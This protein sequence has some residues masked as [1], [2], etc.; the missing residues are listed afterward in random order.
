MQDC[1]VI[2]YII[3]RWFKSNSVRVAQIAQLVEH[4]SAKGK[5]R[6]HDSTFLPAS[7]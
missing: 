1:V 6:F 4:T 2:V 5:A 3:I 7:L